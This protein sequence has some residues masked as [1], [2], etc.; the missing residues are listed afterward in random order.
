MK[1][2]LI[3]IILV[4]MIFSNHRAMCQFVSKEEASLVAQNWIQMVI[5]KYGSWGEYNSASAGPTQDFMY[6][7]RIIGYFC[8]VEPVGYI[9]VSLRKEL[10]PVKAYSETSE[11]D[12]IPD[13]KESSLIKFMM[14]RI[15]DAIESKY[16][17]INLISPGELDDMVSYNFH[18]Q[19]E[20]ILNYTSGQLCTNIMII[21]ANGDYQEGEILLDSHWH[22]NEPYD[23][24]CP[25]QG[26]SNNSGFVKAGCGA[27][28]LGQIMK[29]WSWPPY[30]V[31]PYNDPYDW[32]NMLY[33][34]GLT[35]P[36][37]NQEAVAEL[38][39]EA[40][41]AQGMDY[42]CDES[43]SDFF[44]IEDAI[45]DYFRYDTDSEING[46][47]NNTDDQWWNMIKEDINRNWPI[48]Y[49]I[50]N[51]GISIF[52]SGHFIVADGWQEI[53]GDR[54]IHMNWGSVEIANNTWW[55]LNG[56]PGE[57]LGEIMLRNIR[58][59]VSLSSILFVSTY[60][61]E[62]FPYRYFDRNTVNDFFTSATFESGQYLQM[63]PG[64]KITG[65]A[66]IDDNYIQFLGTSPNITYLYVNGDPTRGI[67]IDNG[68]LRLN[69]NGSLRVNKMPDP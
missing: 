18:S 33:S 13:D 32:A 10:T 57:A 11:Y 66:G 17:P 65:N 62:S 42:H 39:H 67:R 45:D 55:D 26:C 69:N 25:N 37:V 15:I 4:F 36:A 28:A 34:V 9:I 14:S 19:W 50:D 5:D 16:G 58:P 46:R 40:G 44:G 53:N 64:I 35:T 12:P 21:S 8:P 2:Q 68:A 7:G 47:W 22:Q 52:L 29:Y 23:Y 59:N 30:G 31:D 51:D 48:C 54:K 60:P 61:K 38:C 6:N 3:I 43:T 27:I 63:L 1:K 20:Y 56:L 49:R 41:T 24:L